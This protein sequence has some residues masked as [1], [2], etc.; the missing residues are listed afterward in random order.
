MIQRL[1]PFKSRKILAV[2][3]T[4]DV[5]YD[6]VASCWTKMLNQKIESIGK[7]VRASCE[8]T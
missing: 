7:D 1:F 6:G 2:N 3:N 4:Y 5:T 8:T